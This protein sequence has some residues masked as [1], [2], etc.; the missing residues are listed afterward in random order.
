LIVILVETS[1]YEPTSFQAKSES[2][3]Q[4]QQQQQQHLV[5]NAN[6]QNKQDKEDENYCLEFNSNK[7]I[8][9]TI[10]DAFVI[11]LENKATGCDIQTFQI[12]PES[13]GIIFYLIPL[14]YSIFIFI[15]FLFLLRLSVNR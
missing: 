5:S 15:F 13:N 8:N 12:E 9:E 6:E 14:I 10:L 4:Q 7:K 1:Y 3:Q 2:Q 11:Y